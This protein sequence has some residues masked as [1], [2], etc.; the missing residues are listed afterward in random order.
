MG[1]LLKYRTQS[2]G[3]V[4][5]NQD[6]IEFDFEEIITDAVRD[7]QTLYGFKSETFIAPNYV[8][9]D[10]IEMILL[11]TLDFCKEDQFKYCLHQQEYH[12]N[13]KETI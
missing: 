5:G 7:F 10:N 6:E 11:I 1:I 4:D 3:Y 8:W 2:Y 13:I 9:D 12:I